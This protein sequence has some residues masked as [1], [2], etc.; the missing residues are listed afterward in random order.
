MITPMEIHNKEF[1]RRVRGYDQ[2]EV[3]EFLDKIVIDYEK[4]Y[5]ENAELKDKLNLQNEKMSHYI[6]IED[7]LQNTLVMAQKSSEDIETNAREKADIIIEDAKRQAENI[8]KD[9]NYKIVDIIKN[10]QELIKNTKIFKARM[11]SLLESQLDI[12]DE[13][14]KTDAFQT[15]KEVIDHQNFNQ[16]E[17]Q[18]VDSQFE[19]DLEFNKEENDNNYINNNKE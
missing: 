19:E 11:K 1:K 7:T 9:S 15:E 10:K 14:D 3:D 16:G 13:I 8:I 4:L 12:L 6:N 2:D 17:D 18:I 5:R